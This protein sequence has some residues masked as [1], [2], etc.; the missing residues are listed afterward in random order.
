MFAESFAVWL[1]NLGAA[2]AAGAN[3]YDYI[4]V[5]GGTAGLTI[6]RRLS[7]DPKVSV[8]VLEAG[9]DHSEDPNVLVP[10]LFP[11][12]YG[13]PKY[14]W[15]YKTIP[16]TAANDRVFAH[17]RGKQ[18]GGS[19]AVNFMFWT[20]AAQQDIDNWGE[21]GNEGWS[22]K[23]LAPYY[24]RSETFVP[25]SQQ[26]TRDLRLEFV[27]PQ[28]HGY[29]GPIVNAF[30]DLHSPLLPAWPRT[31]ETLGL[32]VNGDPRSGL[33]LGGFV[34]PLSIDPS[35]RER[36]YAANAYLGPIR[37]RTNLKVITGA[38]VDK[39]LVDKIRSTAVAT[40]VQWTKDGAKNTA[41]ARSEVILSAG[42]IASPQILELSGIG[43]K[44][45]LQKH[46]V[47]VKVDNSNVGQNLQD[48]LYVPLGFATQH[49]VP[50]N[51]DFANTTYFQEQLDLYLNN[52]TGRLATSGAS[53]GLLSLPQLASTLYTSGTALKTGLAGLAE[54]YALIAR[55]LATGEV[56]QEL[57]I[58]G[59]ISPQFSNDSTLLFRASAPGNFISVLGVLQHPFSRGSVHIRSRDATTHPEVDPRY[60]SHPADLQLLKVIALHL[61]AVAKTPPLS[62]LLQGGGTVYQPGY[63]RL[64]AENVE[65][66]IRA[67]AQ[68]EYHPCGTA[69]MLP[70]AK[71]GVVDERFR[72]YGVSNLRVVDASV[73]PLIPRAN[74]QSLVYA[75]AERAADFIKRAT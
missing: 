20:H 72:V 41:D 57:I 13:D 48:H 51:E 3:V 17:I 7:D 11:A 37:K 71:G 16:Q 22:W 26:L 27:D 29:K 50:T 9:D 74:T 34:N 8:L 66:W 65:R 59:G 55:G 1:M 53:S 49:G 60:L 32:G 68:S 58:E 39:I 35:R 28:A 46:G 12:M 52:K 36:S 67:A 42:S 2:A 21:L 31:Y 24:E 69:A 56:A 30:P 64:T 43:G 15:D 4:V 14:D 70:R 33:A 62:A 23:E 25:P 47:E 44:R 45:L 6:A 63:H 54:Q 18:L 40:G 5:G 61:Q 10:G 38:F 19:S 75:I 73:F